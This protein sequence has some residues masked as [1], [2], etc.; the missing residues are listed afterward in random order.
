MDTGS[1]AAST[2]YAVHVIADSTEVETPKAMLSLSATAPTMP[3]GYDVFRRLGW[4]RNNSSSNFL[5]FDQNGAG[6]ERFYH[7]D[8]DRSDMKA[9]TAGTAQSWTDIDLSSFIPPTSR[10]TYVSWTFDATNINAGCA[11][12]PKGSKQATSDVADS[13]WFI[14]PVLD[15]DPVLLSGLGDWINTD[16]NRKIQYRLEGSS[17]PRFWVMI[18]GFLDEI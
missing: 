12:A 13:M 9:L 10:V 18:R 4:V 3:S 15:T 14:D 7:Y 6:G 5:R 1:E 17:T 16:V 11:L 2:W 8:E